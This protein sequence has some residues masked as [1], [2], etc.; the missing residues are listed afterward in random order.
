MAQ[1]TMT[2]RLNSSLSDFVALNVGQNG[3]YDNVSEYMRD[4]IRQ[5]KNKVEE[6]KFLRLKTEL[7]QAF[8]APE[9][10]YTP[11]RVEDI[12]NPKPQD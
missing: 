12:I 3:H 10:A 4:L 7:Q 8:Q 2:V 9:S 11:L 1:T 5:D 6:Q